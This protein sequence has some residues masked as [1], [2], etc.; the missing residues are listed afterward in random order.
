MTT[1]AAIV[2][3]YRESH[4]DVWVFRDD[5]RAVVTDKVSAILVS[6]DDVTV[7]EVPLG[8]PGGIF[9][10]FD[11]SGGAPTRD[12]DLR[13]LALR[14]TTA[15]TDPY[16]IVRANGTRF[17]VEKVRAIVAVLLRAG[18]VHARATVN[19]LGALVLVVPDVATLSLMRAG[20][21]GPILQQGV[22]VLD[23]E[24]GEVA[25]LASRLNAAEE[26][27]DGA[28][29]ALMHRTAAMKEA[30]ALANESMAAGLAEC[31]HLRAELVTREKLLGLV[32]FMR[33]RLAR[34]FGRPEMVWS[35]I[36]PAVEVL[37][38]EHTAALAAGSG[39]PI[40]QRNEER[41]GR[42]YSGGEALRLLDGATSARWW[43]DARTGNVMSSRASGDRVVCSLAGQ[44]LNETDTADG[45]L[46]AAAR[47]L[48]TSVAHHAERA[49][50][51]EAKVADEETIARDVVFLRLLEHP[52]PWRVEHDWTY[53]VTAADG[54]IIAKC[55]TAA[56]AAAVVA[57]AERIR[58]DL[59]A[60]DAGRA[61]QDGAA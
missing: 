53:E 57:I 61:T 26:E 39:G 14:L 49:D 52:L 44:R 23:L 42:I 3:H 33:G 19:A 51:A 28:C 38:R 29:L 55:A 2:R 6:R 37:R 41:G 8:M 15:T 4:G 21:G 40:P 45:Q 18:V 58:A 10:C 27:R 56:R 11:M 47:D 36:M 60:A 13:D 46:I 59:D 24:P 25:A 9:T 32:E 31:E 7:G 22:E 35:E 43:F 54:A 20:Q 5:T 34:A 30:Q 50:I 1:A 48:V 16:G 12:V 17:G